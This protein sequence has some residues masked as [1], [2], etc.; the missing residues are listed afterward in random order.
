MADYSREDSAYATSI[1]ERLINR[2]GE[3]LELEQDIVVSDVESDAKVFS[4]ELSLLED[5]NANVPA[6][7]IAG[8]TVPVSLAVAMG[9]SD[10]WP[11]LPFGISTHRPWR[12]RPFFYEVMHDYLRPLLGGERYREGFTSMSRQE[13]RST[14]VRRAADFVATR[15]SAVRGLRNSQPTQAWNRPS[16]L[17]L[18]Q[19]L[20]GPQVSTP[21]CNFTLSTNSN[22]LR[23]FWSGAYY[24]TPNNFNHPTT[25]TSSVLQ[26]GTYIFGVDG[27][28]Y[29]NN[30]QWD[31]NLVVTLPGLPYAHL[32]F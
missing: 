14:F 13:A 30:I 24:V 17:N 31:L 20:R 1:V 5:L 26:S 7:P 15:I 16:L 22:G 29:G 23:V 9:W 27:G 25:P 8:E 3:G 10:R 6:V 21:G 32:N 18:R 12:E 2:E 19:L 4:D 11:L 28:A